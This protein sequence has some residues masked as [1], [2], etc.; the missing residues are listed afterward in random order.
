MDLD[1]KAIGINIA[2]AGRTETYAVPTEA[3]LPVLLDLMSG[4][5]AP[6][7]ATAKPPQPLS[8]A[9]KVAAA[10]AAL[11]RAEAER[12]AAEKKVTEAKAALAEAEAKEKAGKSL[13]KGE[14]K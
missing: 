12:A 5:M 6:D 13:I 8:P 7:V 2:R 14:N 9:E 11:Q 3:V 4:K 1:G 10:K